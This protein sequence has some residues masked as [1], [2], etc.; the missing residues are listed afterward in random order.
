MASLDLMK[1]KSPSRSQRNSWEH[2]PNQHRPTV[3]D[4]ELLPRIEEYWSQGL[5][6]AEI[7]EAIKQDVGAAEK[8]W[9][10]SKRTVYRRRKQLQMAS[11]R[12]QAHTLESIRPY[13]TELVSKYP[14]AGVKRQKDWLT[15][16]RILVSDH[17]LREYN[18]RYH[19]EEVLKRTGKRL[20]RKRFW[21]PGVFATIAMDQHDKWERFGLFMHLGME[22]FSGALLWVEPWWTNKNPRL[23]CSFY[24]RMARAYGGIPM[25]TQSDPGGENNGIANAQTM[26]RQLLDPT[27]IGQLQHK[28]MR[29]H[30]N[31]KPEIRWGQLRREFTRA[32]EDLFDMGVHRGWYD[33]DNPLEY[34]VF[35]WLAIP[36]LKRNLD[37]YIKM[38]NT[39]KPRR[40][41][42]KVLPLGR[43][44]HILHHPE[45]FDN[46]KNFKVLVTEEDIQYVEELYAPPDHPVFQL[47]PPAFGTAIERH[48]RD[49]GAPEVTLDS[50]WDVYHELL[51]AFL[52]CP[53]HA[54]LAQT[55]A[56]EAL[57]EMTIIGEHM[58]LV[59]G[60]EVGEEYFDNLDGLGEDCGEEV[61]EANDEVMREVE[62][63]TTRL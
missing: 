26:L 41:K 55:L 23:V 30:A 38:Y 42:T 27:L 39:S 21:T 3:P 35:R 47:V 6:D 46:A 53:E 57:H 18:Q 60:T 8:G 11:V 44:E 37:E 33:R 31:V 16:K 5:G 40:D 1:T 7:A 2:Q 28:W 12:Q 59:E 36:F 63:L 48:Y 22:T 32:Y 13:M 10:L 20:K 25:L 61:R 14:Q 45:R 9:G 17:L 51:H 29:G 4:E 43:P 15:Q 56:S 34:N 54:D 62:D 50:F 49:L 58:D 19:P 24:L 52:R